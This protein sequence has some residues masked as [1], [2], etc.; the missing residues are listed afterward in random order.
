MAWISV[1]QKMIGGKL[2][3]LYKSIGCSQ[4]EAM[5]ILVYLWLWGIDNAG[6]EG[7]IVSADRSDIAD[8][9]KPGLAPGL[10]AE[11]VVESLIQNHWIDEIDEELYFHDW[12]EW[13]SYYNKYMKE[14]KGNAERQAKYKA[15][16]RQE[17]EENTESNVTDNVTADASETP[18][19]PEKKA[20]KYEKDFETFWAAYPR[21]ADKG[22]C[23][24]KYKARL[25]DGY[26][27][28]ELLLAATNYA[29]QCRRQ[30]TE[31]QFIKHGKTFLGDSMSFTDYLP[32]PVGQ[33]AVAPRQEVGSNP[34]R[35]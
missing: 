33:P 3:S 8:A 32:K 15:K 11:T 18:A 35:R 1:D 34:F 7:L 30:R 17:M 6:A 24:K 27:P 2:R 22:Q 31:P 29:E 28:E 25:K 12:N 13:R 4:Y 5:G 23:Y 10:D 20:P 26:S 16:K 9:I 21:K 19:E 14:K